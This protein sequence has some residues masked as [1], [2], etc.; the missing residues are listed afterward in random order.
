M[1]RRAALSIVA[2]LSLSTVGAGLA[3]PANVKTA[4][5]PSIDLFADRLAPCCDT[6]SSTSP[7]RFQ[8]SN[9]RTLRPSAPN[10]P[11]SRAQTKGFGS[12]LLNFKFEISNLKFPFLA[13]PAAN[14]FLDAISPSLQQPSHTKV[15]VPD[16]DPELQ[17]LLTQAQ[18]A[19]DK[20]DY[21]TAIQIYS[22]A[23]AKYPTNATIH[24]QLG[25]AYTA[26]NDSENAAIHYRRATELD[27][28]MAPAFVNLGLALI[29]KHPAEAIAPLRKAIEL[30]RLPVPYYLLGVALEKNGNISGAIEEFRNAL[31]VDSDNAEI[32]LALARALL[33]TQHYVEAEKEFRTAIALR[34]DEGLAHYG[35][36]E[37][38]LEQK[39]NEAA[40]AELATYLQSSP[41]DATAH[42]KRASILTDLGKNEEALA[43][44]DQAAVV[45]P[46]SP[47]T[48]KLR[49]LVYFRLKKYDLSA[50]ALQKLETAAPG[51]TDIH[52]R[53]GHVLLEKKDYPGAVKELV[54]AYRAD[55]KQNDVLHDLLLAEYQGGNYAAT[56]ALLDEIGKHETLAITS[57][58]IRASC[59]DKLGQKQEAIDTYRKFL[60]LND[61]KTNDEYFVSAERVRVLER[62]LKEKK[63]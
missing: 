43:E 41:K 8:V 52:A 47:E 25:Y 24:F 5:T 42:I 21:A 61:G 54:I 33:Q 19:L 57:V 13:F 11:R 16:V 39:K 31:D 3:P 38:L 55:P 18:Q 9:P 62:E 17:R 4:R 26:Q 30:H 23:A 53:L 44:L 14:H 7:P 32:H 12:P 15:R 48:L 22:D 1:R 51:D 50:A 6:P 58:Y 59:Y 35:H 60:E 36:A 49:S 28:Q 20:N 46:E 34:P 2:S 37:C 63:K 40:A 29:D 27:P 10:P 45:H 56:L